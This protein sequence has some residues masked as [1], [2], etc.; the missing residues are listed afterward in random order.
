[1]LEETFG[2]SQNLRSAETASLYQAHP[3]ATLG[4]VMLVIVDRF[5]NSLRSSCILNNS[6]I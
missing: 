3:V 2:L 1:M 6:T 4:K 5:L